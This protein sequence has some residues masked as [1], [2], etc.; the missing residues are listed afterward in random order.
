MRNM[1]LNEDDTL[2]RVNAGGQPVEH[3]FINVF[4][5]GLCV[6]QSGESMNVHDAIDAIIFILESNVVLYRSHIVTYVLPTR[7]ACA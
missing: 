7:R 5:K 1:R 4:P 2:L 6:L 3:H